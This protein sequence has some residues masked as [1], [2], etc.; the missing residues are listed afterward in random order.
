MLSFRYPENPLLTPDSLT[1]VQEGHEIVGVFNAGVARMG[2]ETILLLRVAERPS[3]TSDTVVAWYYDAAQQQMRRR[4]FD[5][6]DPE[7]DVSDPRLIVTTDTVYLTSLSYLRLARSQDGRKF[8]VDEGVWLWPEQAHESF[9]LEDPRITTLDGL[10]RIQYVAVSPLGVCTCLATTQ[11][12]G[13]V[14]RNGIIFGP[15]N[16]DVAIFPDR[17]NGR[18][19]ALHR[20]AS[21]FS[22]KNEMWIA[23]SPDLLCWGHHRHCLG[24][25]PG[26]WDGRRIGAGAP[27][28]RIEQ[29][30]LAIYHG[31]DAENRYCLGAVLLDGREPWKVLARSVQPILEPETDYECG[32][33]YGGVVFTCGALLVGD[34]LRIY[35]GAADTCMA[36]VDI[37]LAQVL[38]GMK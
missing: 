23:E 31:A 6:G 33:F 24:L 35:Y 21:P 14:E 34:R 15:E 28:L 13:R 1:P 3:L 9:G 30:W 19:Y 32:G 16:K 4:E 2:L 37:P 7:I 5:R 36:G 22:L 29:G 25:R 18:Y 11:D 17:V 20:P 10:Y 38:A 12:F 27:P 8:T 26:H